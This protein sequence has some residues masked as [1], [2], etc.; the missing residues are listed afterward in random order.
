[1]RMAWPS[2]RYC[3][4]RE[5]LEKMVTVTPW[6]ARSMAV[7]KTSAPGRVAVGRFVDRRLRLILRPKMTSTCSGR[8]R[9][10]LSATSVSKNARA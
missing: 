8:P 4:T 6:L 7:L 1:M 10:R 5:C 3:L 2:L 9:S